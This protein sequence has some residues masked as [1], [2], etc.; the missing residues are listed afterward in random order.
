MLRRAAVVTYTF[1]VIVVN[2]AMVAATTGQ[3]GSVMLTIFVNS[4][5]AISYALNAAVRQFWVYECAH[6][7]FGATFTHTWVDAH[8]CAP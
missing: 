1:A 4:G 6:V 2:Y 7:W 5:L 3:N 8:S